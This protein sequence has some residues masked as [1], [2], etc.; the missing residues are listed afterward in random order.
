MEHLD[1]LLIGRLSLSPE[2]ANNA[3]TFEYLTSCWTRLYAAQ[4][5]FVKTNA[6]Q[7]W[8]A[9]EG[10]RWKGTW[11]KMKELVVSYVGYT[12]EDPAMFPQPEG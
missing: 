3:T 7:G 9:D 4:R 2:E 12:L 1:A 5:D 6:S 8:S 10:A 11:E